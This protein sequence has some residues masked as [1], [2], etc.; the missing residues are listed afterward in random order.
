MTNWKLSVFFGILRKFGGYPLKCNRV[1]TV[2]INLFEHKINSKERYS[3]LMISTH[4]PSQGRKENI[5]TSRRIPVLSRQIVF[6]C[7]DMT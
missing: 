5:L 6:A 1:V 2:Q 4:F 7:K 3:I